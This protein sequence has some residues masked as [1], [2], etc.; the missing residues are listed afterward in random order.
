VKRRPFH[1]FSFYSFLELQT[2]K[3]NLRTKMKDVRNIVQV[4]MADSI[5]CISDPMVGMHLEGDQLQHEGG[6][7]DF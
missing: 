2:N 6:S 5:L 1:S 4:G 7:E 3:I